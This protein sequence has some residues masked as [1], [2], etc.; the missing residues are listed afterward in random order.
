MTT[1]NASVLATALQALKWAI[2]DT[3]CPVDLIALIDAKID[4][5]YALKQTKFEVTE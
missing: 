5:E 3:R 2:K 4:I 1:V